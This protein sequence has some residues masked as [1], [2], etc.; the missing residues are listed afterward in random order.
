V[1]INIGDKD[2]L[3]PTVKERKITV[4]LIANTEN[5]S[6]ILKLNLPDGWKADSIQQELY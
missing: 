2:Y 1:A 4:T 5:I 6:G 3:F